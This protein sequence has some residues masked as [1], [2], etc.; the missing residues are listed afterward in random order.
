MSRE[1]ALEPQR[2]IHDAVLA[3]QD[4]IVQPPAADEP[5]LLERGDV[6]HEAEGSRRR[7]FRAKRLR[8]AMLVDH[9]FASDRVRIVERVV[10]LESVGRLERDVFPCARITDRDAPFDDEL[11][12]LFGLDLDT[13]GLEQIAEFHRRAVENRDLALH[14]DA[15]VGD[16]EAV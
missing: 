1:L 6:F 10:D 11:L 7:D 12:D 15:Q 8:A 14:L 9:V 2:G 4:A 16:A 13:P 3:D 5:H